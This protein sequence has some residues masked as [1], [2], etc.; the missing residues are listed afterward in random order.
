MQCSPGKKWMLNY[1]NKSYTESTNRIPMES[2]HV[3]LSLLSFCRPCGQEGLA[4]WAEGLYIY[5]ILY[6]Y[7]FV[8]LLKEQFDQLDSANGAT[9]LNIQAS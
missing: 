3:F 9:L 4:A 2:T 7:I 5:Y 6:I 1:V 8:S